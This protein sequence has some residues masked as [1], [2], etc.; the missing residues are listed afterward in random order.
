MSDKNGEGLGKELI[1]KLQE[2]RP[3]TVTIERTHKDADTA[4]PLVSRPVLQL[5]NCQNL[6]V[7]DFYPEAVA[8]VLSAVAFI[9]LRRISI[10]TTPYTRDDGIFPSIFTQIPQVIKDIAHNAVHVD[11]YAGICDLRLSVKGDTPEGNLSI[12]LS[13]HLPDIDSHLCR[14]L[15]IDLLQ[16]HV[17]QFGMKPQSLGFSIGADDDA[18]SFTEDIW[19][20]VLLDCDTAKKLSLSLCEPGI[21]GP[22]LEAFDVLYL[23]CPELIDLQLN[24]G[25]SNFNRDL[26][27]ELLER[28]RGIGAAIERISNSQDNYGPE[29][30]E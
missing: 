8:H 23:V 20:S 4:F 13:E 30:D 24:I 25:H 15:K 14:D 3:T 7:T 22:F 10:T 28:R 9:S 1:L 11:Y 26:F 6:T 21:L 18:P 16:T 5:D 29:D 12:E 2:Q 27:E 17:Q 19:Q